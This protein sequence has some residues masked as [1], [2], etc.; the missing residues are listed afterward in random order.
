MYEVLLIATA[1]S[2]GVFAGAQLMEAWVLAPFWR[3]LSPPRFFDLY[4]T[5]GPI[6]FR[7]FAPL[8]VLSV[9]LSVTTALTNKGSV[10]SILAASLC[11]SALGIF[12]V[13][14]RIANERLATRAVP[15]KKLPEAL[16]RWTLWHQFRTVIVTSSFVSSLLAL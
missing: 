16:K 1:I 7:F 8:T 12:F 3:S 13:Y 9:L 15:D 4:H 6:L 10:W 5:M 14:F 2:L 11:L